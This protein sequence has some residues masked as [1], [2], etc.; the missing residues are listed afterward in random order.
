[1]LHKAA[2]EG[3]SIF[4]GTYRNTPITIGQSGHTPPQAHLIPGLT[5]E[6]CDYVNKNWRRTAIH[7]CAYVMWRMNWVHPF[8]DGNSRTS[9]ITAYMVLALSLGYEVPGVPT[10]PE[11]IASNKT[12]YYKALEKADKAWKRGKVDVSA[13]E[14]MLD[15]MIARQLLSV[16][17]EAV[18]K[19][20]RRRPGKLH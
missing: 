11:Q 10:V 17:N 3:L 2:L 14:E 9:R 1:M 15:T 13:I 4:A 18:G 19:Q 20:A 16:R 5:Q 7:L 8:T 6:M 12:P